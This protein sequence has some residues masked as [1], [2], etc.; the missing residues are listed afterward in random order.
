VKRK[1]S[2]KDKHA[3]GTLPATMAA[4]A[5][6]IAMLEAKLADADLY[7]RDAKAFAA[8]SDRLTFARQEYAA[9]EDRWLELEI[10]REELGG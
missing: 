6:E 10:L 9:A 1:L 2:F 5:R 8:A 4:L 3:L 7:A